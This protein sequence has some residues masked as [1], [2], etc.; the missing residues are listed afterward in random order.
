MLLKLNSLILIKIYF[1]S[2]I[3]RY[4]KNDP[5]RLKEIKISTEKFSLPKFGQR[6][7]KRVIIT[8]K[9]IL[10]NTFHNE[11]KLWETIVVIDTYLLW[12]NKVD[13]I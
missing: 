13:S 5:K 2:F 12:Q 4:E 1:F 6:D 11:L 9:N 8:A 7:Q 3:F 10:R